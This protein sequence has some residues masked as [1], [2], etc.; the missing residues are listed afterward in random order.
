[1]Q[2]CGGPDTVIKQIRAFHD[3]TGVGILDLSFGRASQ[4]MTLAAIRRF[5][6]QV[7]PKIRDLAASAA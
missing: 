3:A 5:G 6:E 4:E 2:F 7:L 1:V